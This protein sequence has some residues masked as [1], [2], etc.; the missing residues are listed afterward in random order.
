MRHNPNKAFLALKLLVLTGAQNPRYSQLFEVLH[1]RKG[2]KLDRPDRI[3]A[4][5]P[6]KE[7]SLLRQRAPGARGFRTAWLCREPRGEQTRV[8]P[9]FHCPCSFHRDGQEHGEELWNQAS[10]RGSESQERPA[11]HP[12]GRPL[13]RVSL[14]HRQ[15]ALRIQPWSHP[16]RN[17]EEK[18]S[19]EAL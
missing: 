12:T 2:I 8:R 10:L 6:A 5:V 1:L 15:N 16:P 14:D 13:Q 7:H 17:H 19:R 4:E 11:H 9:G 3:L 18:T